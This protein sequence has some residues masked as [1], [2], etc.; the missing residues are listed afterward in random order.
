VLPDFSAQAVTLTVLAHLDRRRHAI[1]D[2]PGEV[3]AEVLAAL[4]PV[5]EAYREAE[6][7]PE[8]M[9]ALATEIMESVPARWRA[10]ATRFS[11]LEARDFDVWRGGDPIARLTYVLLALVIGG[12]FVWAPFIPIWDQWFPFALAGGAWWLPTAQVGWQ[13]RRYARALGAIAR[14]LATTQP[15][16]DEHIKLN[17]LLLPAGEDEHE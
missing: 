14:D 10:L 15:R 12:I 13:R 5:R 6:L 1:A 11:A 9:E 2:D 3:H 17:E 16:L 8:Y 4:V 7:P